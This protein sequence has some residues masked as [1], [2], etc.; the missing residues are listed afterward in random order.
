MDHL[1][2]LKFFIRVV[3][4]N[5]I[6]SAGRDFGMSPATASN[7]LKDL[8][9]YYHAKLINRT[10]RSIS[11]TEEGR[12]LHQRARRLIN[13]SE[14]LKNLIKQSSSEISGPIKFAAT[15]DLG[16]NLMAPLLDKFVEQNPSVIIQ[17]QLEDDNVD[18]ID[19]GIDLAIRL[20][21]FRDS[22]LKGRKLASN[23]RVACAAPAYLKAHGTPQH[24]DELAQHNCLIMHWGHTIDHEWS[25]QIDDTKYI[26]TVAGNRSANNGVQVK[27]WCLQGYGI[28]YKSIW[29][30]KDYL[31]SGELVEVL[32]DY[33]FK[34]D[35]AVQLLYPG[36]YQPSRR[37]RALIDFLVDAFEASAQ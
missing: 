25:F 9:A 34:S 35:S 18:L 1:D 12:L 13:D 2:S 22:S 21:Q 14:E 15:Q 17:L 33:N 16:A 37:V 8:E 19:Q 26:V 6:S 29:D 30:V 11:L 7:R 10:T 36:G 5:G 3:E 28:A 24:P 27:N 20:G 32:N 4:K 23:R 31:A